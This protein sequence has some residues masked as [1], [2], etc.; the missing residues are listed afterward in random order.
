MHKKN[1]ISHK[2]LPKKERLTVVPTIKLL[3][4]LKFHNKVAPELGESTSSN[5]KSTSFILP[6]PRSLQKTNSL[7]LKSR[8]PVNGQSDSLS[9]EQYRKSE[10]IESR[11]PPQSRYPYWFIDNF[12]DMDL[13][14]TLRPPGIVFS[15]YDKEAS[16]KGFQVWENVRIT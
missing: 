6:P 4:K 5:S 3:P 1:S 2:V 16:L 12:Y 15:N 11:R 7:I 14:R 10:I 13:T 8:E 9:F